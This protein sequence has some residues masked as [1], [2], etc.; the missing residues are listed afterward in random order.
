MSR[1]IGIVSGKGGVGK[2]TV[3]ANLGAALAGRGFDRKVMVVD[4]NLTTSHLSMYL[5][6][7][8][9]PTTLNEVLKGSAEIGS[10]AYLHESGMSVIPASLSFGEGM[11]HG[12]KTLKTVVGRLFGRADIILLDCAPGLGREATSAIEASDEVLFVTNPNIPAVT[13]AL[14]CSRVAEHA[15]A[16]RLGVVINMAHGDRSHEL[17]TR[18]IEQFT[19]LPVI[20]VIPFDKNV[21]RSLDAR[22]PVVTYRPGSRASAAF[23]KLA[24]HLMN[25]PVNEPKKKKGRGIIG[26][27][28]RFFGKK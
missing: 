25:E 21:M 17:S 3:V 13:D 15:G 2:T 16:K 19:E 23:M 12:M 22:K 5:G 28:L 14:R 26:R 11:E 20:G 4:C 6:L 8:H 9:A 18:E 10:A 27:L 24:A 7:H 1:I